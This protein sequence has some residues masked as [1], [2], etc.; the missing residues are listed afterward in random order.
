MILILKYF[1]RP[2]RSGVAFMEIVS[3]Q[4]LRSPDE[5]S[6][7]I[8]KLRSI[9]KYLGPGNGNMQEGSLKAM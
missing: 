2:Y 6:L 7:Y 4:N 3:K 8:K 5:V 9:M 1:C